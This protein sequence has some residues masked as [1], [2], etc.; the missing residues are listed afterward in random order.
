MFK[1]TQHTHLSPHHC[2]LPYLYLAAP[3]RGLEGE[4]AEVKR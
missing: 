4:N 1:R 2:L 3:E